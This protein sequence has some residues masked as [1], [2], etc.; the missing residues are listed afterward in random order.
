[1]RFNANECDVPAKKICLSYI[2][3]IRIKLVVALHA[4]SS[5]LSLVIISE[6]FSTINEISHCECKFMKQEV[7]S[8]SA[9]KV[10]QDLVKRVG[11]TNDTIRR[12][13]QILS[14]CHAWDDFILF[15]EF[16]IRA[17]SSTNYKERIENEPA[18]RS[19]K[20]N[21]NWNR[22]FWTRTTCIKTAFSCV[23]GTMS[24]FVVVCLTAQLDVSWHEINSSCLLQWQLL[25]KSEHKGTTVAVKA[26]WLWTQWDVQNVNYIHQYLFGLL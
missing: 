21:A 13:Q 3:T 1:M 2:Q 19:S 26:A 22:F 20:I 18:H 6:V 11:E 14:S 10:C 7:S 15:D 23:L 12:P 25:Q 17:P 24:L 4:N 16:S 9:D 8:I 5:V